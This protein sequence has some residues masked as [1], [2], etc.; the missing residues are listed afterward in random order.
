MCLVV[1]STCDGFRYYVLEDDQ[2]TLNYTEH[3]RF[4]WLLNTAPY[5]VMQYMEGVLTFILSVDFLLRLYLSE[6]KKLFFRSFLIWA[7]VMGLLPIWCMFLMQ[8]L[9]KKSDHTPGRGLQIA[10]IIL[11]FLRACRVLKILHV[12][13]NYK[14]IRLIW[15]TLRKGRRYVYRYSVI[16]LV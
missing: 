4:T 12:I 9:I 11:S 1:L 10:V 3:P 2:H 14:S 15:L 6:S 7:D 8:V 16:M 5:P 13:K